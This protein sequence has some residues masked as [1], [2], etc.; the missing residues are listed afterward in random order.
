MFS[1]A[2]ALR[3][4]SPGVPLIILQEILTKSCE[5]KRGAPCRARTGTEDNKEWK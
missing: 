1:E 2:K 5:I 3:V 4:L